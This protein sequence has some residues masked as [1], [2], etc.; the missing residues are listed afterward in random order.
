M[1]SPALAD[2]ARLEDLRAAWRASGGNLRIEGFLGED[3]ARRALAA[4]RVEPHRLALP[5]PD[6]ALTYQF[7]AASFAPEPDCEHPL[8]ALGRFLLGS[9][10]EWVEAL[11]GQAL[12]PAPDR[13]VAAGAYIKGSYLD[14]HDDFG[15]GRALAFVLGLTPEPWPAALGGHLEFL[16]PAGAVVERRA[17]GWNTLDLFDVRAPGRAHRVPIL[18]E[19]LERRTV[20]GW[21]YP[22]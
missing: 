12:A 16:D 13:A 7:W 3:A 5:S 15:R 20:Y 2:P 4:A 8:C 22:R 1:L 17:P 21:Y 18:R 14:P 11:T 6:E 10:R 9:G 19:H